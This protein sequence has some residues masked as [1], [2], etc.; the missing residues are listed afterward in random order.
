MCAA[1]DAKTLSSGHDGSSG[2]NAAPHLSTT[3]TAARPEEEEEEVELLDW[4]DDNDDDTTLKP[5][6]TPRARRRWPA[7]KLDTLHRAL[8]RVC[9]G[10]LGAGQLC[11]ARIAY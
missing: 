7:W 1:L 11:T 9:A 3:R 10:K 6:L 5:H 4:D 2:R 8:G